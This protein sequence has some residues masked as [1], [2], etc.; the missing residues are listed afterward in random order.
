MKHKHISDEFSVAGQVNTD[1]I[2]LLDAMGFRSLVCNRPDGEALDQP[3]FE[4]I[5]NVAKRSNIET[6]YLPVKAG[7]PTDDDV[8]QLRDLVERLP[9]P[10]LVYCG[11]GARSEA[12]LSRIIKT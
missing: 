8:E 12:L 10:V 3:L 9:K 11:T 2:A 5:R 1:D 6:A 7:V 4:T